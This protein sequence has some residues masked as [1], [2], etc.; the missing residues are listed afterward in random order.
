MW[1]KE[2]VL[3]VLTHV[4]KGVSVLYT[5]SIL[6]YFSYLDLSGVLSSVTVEAYTGLF[7]PAQCWP[8][9]NCRLSRICPLSMIDGSIIVNHRHVPLHSYSKLNAYRIMQ[10][11][12]VDA[13]RHL[14]FI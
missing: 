7:D 5:T 2:Y 9:P 10:I 6:L 14:L 12:A 3:I 8:V 1:N 13:Q 11:D 4:E